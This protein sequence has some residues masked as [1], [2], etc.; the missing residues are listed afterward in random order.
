MPLWSADLAATA[1]QAPSG[2]RSADWAPKLRVNIFYKVSSNAS[3][4]NAAAP[5]KAQ[6]TSANR[7]RLIM[8]SP[9]EGGIMPFRG[10]GYDSFLG[11][12]RN[13]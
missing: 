10:R 2:D 6:S 12:A 4:A 11:E 9:R 3:S 13:G 7:A 1:S 5:A 8:M